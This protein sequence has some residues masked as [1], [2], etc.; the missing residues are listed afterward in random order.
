MDSGKWYWEA[1]CGQDDVIVGISSNT[2][3]SPGFIGSAGE[4]GYQDNGNKF[5]AS[6]TG[7]SYG[8]T[9]KAGDV[10]GVAF[11]ANSGNIWFSVNGTWQNSATAAE[12]AA[13]TTDNAAFTSLANGFMFRYF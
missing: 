13:G 3:S 6:G 9:F 2:R 12:I 1:T 5:N 8:S 11:D 4:I 7:S 10:I